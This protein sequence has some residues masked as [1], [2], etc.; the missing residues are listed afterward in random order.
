MIGRFLLAALTF[1]L[2]A[3]GEPVRAQPVSHAKRAPDCT[4]DVD[5]TADGGLRAAMIYRCRSATPVTFNAANGRAAA[6]VMAFTDADGQPLPRSGGAW[7][8]VPVNGLAEARYTVDLLA[9]ARDIDR[10]RMAIARGGGVLTLLEGWLL[11]PRGLGRLPVI[12]IR[13]KA[14][15]GLAFTSGLPK[16]GDAWRLEGTPIRFAGYSALGR[17]DLRE[18]EVPAPGSLR[19]GEPGRKGVLRLALLDG[20][21]A[22][23]RADLVDWVRR[24]AE[25]ESN[26]WRGFTADQSMLGLV[27]MEGRHGVGFGRT[28]PGGGA[29]IMVEVGRDVE[30]RRLFDD[31][32]LV[33]ELIHT[34]MPFIDGG[35]TWL[36]EG[37]ATY[38]EPIIR[39]RAGWKTEDE[40]WKEWIDHMPRG[41]GAF[42]GGLADA[43]GQ[44][45]Y[46]GGA[47]FML[48]AD[49]GIRRATRG[50][51]GL[52]DCL[53]GALWAGL[54]ATRRVSVEEFARACDRATAT[55]VMSALVSAHYRKRQAV[56][57]AA[58]WKRLGVGEAAGRI[59]YDDSAPD[60]RWRKMI[61]TGP[62]GRPA[63]R[64]KLPW[65]S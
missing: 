36:M 45:N 32:V 55:E 49:V 24:T 29:T 35:G 33:H 40:V 16:V 47:T 11:E 1:M 62:P 8:V 23:G 48:M 28:V 9:Y 57:L 65:Q 63:Q 54:D 64:V 30:Q 61:V 12:D 22:E 31:W 41:S 50:A 39:A 53:D 38:V 20:F 60:A 44:E 56:D 58:L 25:A 13:V 7:R 6:D 3:S 21:N 10:P 27:P 15:D 46:W 42:T 4:V 5:V 17:F 26:Y 18:I 2:G 37:A 14:A 34:G 51:R 59:T 52:E 43:E 19:R